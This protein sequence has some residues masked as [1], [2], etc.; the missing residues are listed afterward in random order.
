[1]AAKEQTPTQL[2][3]YFFVLTI[4]GVIAWIAL[5]ISLLQSP[6]DPQAVQDRDFET[7]VW[8]AQQ[9]AVRNRRGVD[10]A[11]NLQLA[12]RR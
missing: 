9:E 4:F 6:V 2:A 7:S 10:D 12:V 1:M 11:A 3:R 5:A 8:V